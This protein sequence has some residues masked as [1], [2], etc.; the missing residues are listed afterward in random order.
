MAN[1]A[2]IEL[3]NGVGKASKQPYTMAVV[4]IDGQPVNRFFP[5][6]AE[7]VGIKTLLKIK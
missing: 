5:K 7:L 3:V 2:E 4:K 1:N 6:D